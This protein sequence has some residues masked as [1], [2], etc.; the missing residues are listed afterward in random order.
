MRRAWIGLLLACL[1]SACTTL[2]PAEPPIE[3][4]RHLPA[5]VYGDD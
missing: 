3:H 4:W 2:R 5:P 1:V